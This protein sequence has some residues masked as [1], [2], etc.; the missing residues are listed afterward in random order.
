[1]SQLNSGREDDGRNRQP[2]AV[3]RPDLP[4]SAQRQNKPQ[5]NQL[6]KQVPIPIRFENMSHEARKTT[7]SQRRAIE[8]LLFKS[9]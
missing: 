3:E 2:R 7:T 5:D 6:V 8:M 9:E 1:M 4:Q